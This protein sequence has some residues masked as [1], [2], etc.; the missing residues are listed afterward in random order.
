[1][2]RLTPFLA[3]LGLAG[4]T[5]AG[6]AAQASCV[7]L[8]CEAPPPFRTGI[9]EELSTAGINAL[10]GGV[11]AA[12]TRLVQG[13][14]VGASFWKGALGGGVVYAGKRVAVE[15]F[16]GAGLVGRE[17][18]SVGG[19]MVRNAAAGR[20]TLEELVLPVGPVRLY[21]SRTHGVV[22]RLDVGTVIASG[23]FM[24]AYDARLDLA[25]SLSAG[26]LVFRGGAPTP[27]LT[28]AG[29]VTIWRDADMPASEGPRLLAHER[30][31]VLQYDQAFLS[32]GEGIERWLVERS[33]P[34]SGL[35]DHLDFGAL[36]MGLRGSLGF[37]LPYQDRPWEKEAYFLAQSAH[38]LPPVTS[39]P[40]I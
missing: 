30:V 8:S 40:A 4:A 29:A 15:G 26:A 31:H 39:D 27:G 23:A 20:G 35:L 22:P 34:R 16:D 2:A 7:T 1:M 9:R 33:A 37:T 3:A 28:S 6:A 12:V 25:E 10:L 11:T 24:V 17:V 18:A 5:A 32:W 38:P 19:S 21:V 36:S 13:E 14:P